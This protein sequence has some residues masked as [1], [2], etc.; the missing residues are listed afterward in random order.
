MKNEIIMNYYYRCN[1]TELTYSLQRLQWDHPNIYLAT[2]ADQRYSADIH[3]FISFFLDTVCIMNNHYNLTSLSYGS[4]TKIGQGM[5]TNLSFTCRILTL[6]YI[7]ITIL[8]E[9]SR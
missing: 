7:F 4:D 6:Q 8:F 9:L 3:S 1:A 2:R 5:H